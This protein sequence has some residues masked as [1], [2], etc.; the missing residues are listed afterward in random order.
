MI[1]LP[2]ISNIWIKLVLVMACLSAIVGV[3]YGLGWK[4]GS[5]VE[6]VAEDVIQQEIGEQIPVPGPV[7]KS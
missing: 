7:A 3:K 2:S 5:V 4:D 6:V 1:Q